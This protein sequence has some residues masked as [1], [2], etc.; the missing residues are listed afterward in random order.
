MSDEQDAGNVMLNSEAAI[1]Y[2]TDRFGID[3]DAL[4]EAVDI[5]GDS[6]AA[7]AAYLN[8]DR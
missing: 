6:V 1:L 7:V 5:V 2:W 3:R 8:T 4:E